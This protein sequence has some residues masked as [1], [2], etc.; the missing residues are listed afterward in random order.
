[1]TARA[2]L[3]RS[4]RYLRSAR[5]LLADADAASCVSRAYYAM[6]YAAEAALLS[7]GREF[8]SHVGVISA[9]GEEFVITGILPP[10]LGRTLARAFRERQLSDYDVQ[11]PVPTELAEKLIADGEEFVRAVEALL[12][13]A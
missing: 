2:L 11:K 10:H 1:M 4:Q 13:K 7:R 9:F 5:L 8:R 3:D 6:F 12:E